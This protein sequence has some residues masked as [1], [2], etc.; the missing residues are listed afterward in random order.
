MK[1]MNVL[2]KILFSVALVIG[3]LLV[4]YLFLFSKNVSEQLS[5]KMEN[6]IVSPA[7][8][9]L[10]P[11]MLFKEEKGEWPISLEELKQFAQDFTKETL[12]DALF[13][14]PQY[15][16]AKFKVMDD[17]NFRIILKNDEGNEYWIGTE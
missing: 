7:R 5:H 6:N 8:D 14:D 2:Y 4:A 9:I 3:I 15:S 17:G 10:W 12:P 1:R 11:C 13:T 16:C